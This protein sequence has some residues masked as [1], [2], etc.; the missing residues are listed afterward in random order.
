MKTTKT[1]A[2][3]IGD[4]ELTRNEYIKEWL[5][6]TV[7]VGALFGATHSVGKYFEFRD[8]VAELAGQQWDK[9]E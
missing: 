9:A 4:K 7:Q 3:W 5:D 2:S 1:F 6:S 8:L